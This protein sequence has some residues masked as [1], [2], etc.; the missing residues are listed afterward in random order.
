M[1]PARLPA[2]YHEAS[3]RKS[4]NSVGPNG[5]DVKAPGTHEA[6]LSSGR[7]RVARE[8]AGVRPRVRRPYS[9][10][11]GALGVHR[12]EDEGVYVTASSTDDKE[13]GP[14]TVA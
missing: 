7:A 11:K 10:V 13:K 4:P 8:F 5:I 12:A 9:E 6:K 14:P 1:R 2:A 3:T